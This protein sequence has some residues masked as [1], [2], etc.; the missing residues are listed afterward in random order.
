MQLPFP[1]EITSFF[2]D[3]PDHVIKNLMITTQGIY[4]AKSTNLNLVKDELGNILEN[5]SSTKPAS[6]YKRLIRFFQMADKEKQELTKS[7]LCVSFCILGLKAKQPK[8]L[9]LDGTSWELGTKKIHLLTLAIVI[10]GV[11]IPICWEELDKKGTSN[12][13]ERKALFDKAL[14]WYNLK[15]MILL[16]D[17]EYIGEKW[18]KYLKNN[19]LEFVIRLKKNN[20]KE[21]VDAQRQ[22]NSK[23]FSHQK[24]RHI[25]MEKEA[26][27]QKYSKV[28][29]AKKIKMDA[30]RLNWFGG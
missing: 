9:N 24:W 1:D 30:H 13:G 23:S 26:Y 25:G 19:G 16:A 15:G 11:S 4:A 7:L 21:Y 22:G 27:K 5:Q 8:Y 17:R 3:Q 18:F 29:V 20:Y 6:N 10:N 2:P 14:K 28:G 12:F